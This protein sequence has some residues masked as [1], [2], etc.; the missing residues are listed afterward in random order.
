[1]TKTI[2]RIDA[3]ARHEGSVTRDLT[4]RIV[5][6]TPDA[7][8]IT[9][10]LAT[11]LPQLDESWINANFTPKGDR[12]A[13]Q[14]ARLAQSDELIAEIRAAD[15]LVI[16][17]PI[18][19]FG[20]PAAFKAW[21]DLI[22]RVGETFQ[23]GETGPVGLLTGKRAVVAIASGGT[24]LGSDIEFASNYVRH[25]LGFIGITEVTFVAAD[26]LAI[27]ADAS[28]FSAH[29]AIEALSIAA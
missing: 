22:A 16:G 14:N 13:D 5:A 3:S 1:M 24:E 21:V 27:D 20:V 2:L 6:R 25:L 26:Q 15:T 7:T 18:Y 4:S 11:A 17:I 28:L 19:N 10:D 8:V 9:R 29:G 23:Y 12:N